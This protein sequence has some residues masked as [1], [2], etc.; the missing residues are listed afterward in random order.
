MPKPS[1]YLFYRTPY[2]GLLSRRLIKLRASSILEWFQQGWDQAM[3]S[4]N[5][6][7]DWVRDECGGDV[8][9]LES[10]FEKARER[11][12]DR[13]QTWQHLNVEGRASEYIKM[14]AQS[15]RVKTDD[16][17]NDLAICLEST[18]ESVEYL[19]TDFDI[20]KVTA[21]E[22]RRELLNPLYL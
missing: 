5:D 20:L 18:P 10:I 16:D 3:E 22:S 17:E 21:S 1:V 11:N 12:L 8:Y 7:N 19:F 6:L 2:A 4:D 15:L 13:P 9:G 14:D